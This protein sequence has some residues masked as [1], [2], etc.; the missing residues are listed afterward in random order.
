MA[1]PAAQAILQEAPI[2]LAS[3]HGAYDLDTN[4]EPFR[5]PNNTIL[6]ETVDIGES[7]LTDIDLPLWNLIQ[8][9]SRTR[10]LTYMRGYVDP[11]DS[12]SDQQKFMRIFNNI[13]IY[14]PGDMVYNRNLTIG[15]GLDHNAM[16]RREVRHRDL[17]IR[18]RQSY[19]NMGFYK[20]KLGAI[21]DKFPDGPR[22]KILSA[23]RTKLIEDDT[24]TE[25]YESILKH[26]KKNYPEDK[27]II[28]FSCCGVKH[29]GEGQKIANVQ[30]VQR[31]ADLK[32][33]TWREEPI[34]AKNIRM[35]NT[36]SRK[37]NSKNLHRSAKRRLNSNAYFSNEDADTWARNEIFAFPRQSYDPL[38][39][40]GT[41]VFE[42]MPNGSQKQVM[43]ENG[44]RYFNRNNLNRM[45]MRNNSRQYS[46][47][48]NGALVALKGRKTKRNRG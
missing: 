7:C 34:T 33:K 45:T 11:D 8:G 31:Q 38:R 35:A 27:Q 29:Y 3:V 2:F 26:L 46:T 18:H 43:K 25:T 6:I 42:R 5:V 16:E 20:F 19:A 39:K 40:T 15:G 24:A 12:K 48:K 4:P 10:M 21:P 28:I 30:E 23:L 14:E 41:Q 32:F 13:H 17:S 47:L 37:K 22:S 44:S 1:T 36:Y 9:T